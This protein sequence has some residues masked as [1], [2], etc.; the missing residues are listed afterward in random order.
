MSGAHYCKI[1]IVHLD[2]QATLDVTSIYVRAP[3]GPMKLDLWESNRS[4]NG[5]RITYL[6]FIDHQMIPNT[7]LLLS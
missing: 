5:N 3:I 6:I 4:V 2:A 7:L 1:L